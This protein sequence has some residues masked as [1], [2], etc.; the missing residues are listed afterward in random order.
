[1]I[2]EKRRLFKMWKKS[3][4]EVDRALYCIAK[5]NARKAVYIAQSDEQKVFGGMLDSEFEQGT[6]F[7]VVKQMVGKNREQVVSK[8]QMEN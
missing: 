1:M 3:K 5:R 4:T 2:D 6:V 8:G 7:R